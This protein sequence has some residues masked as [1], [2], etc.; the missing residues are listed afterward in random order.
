[1]SQSSDQAREHR[2]ELEE[3]K[4][5]M[6]SHL[7]KYLGRYQV[8][9]ADP[10]WKYANANV[11]GAASHH[12]KTMS[13][14]E[15]CAL[16]VSEIA[17]KDAMLLLWATSPL[18]PEALEVMEAWGFKFKTVFFAWVKVKKDSTTPIKANGYWTR[19]CLEVCLLGV[20]G[21]VSNLQK[22]KQSNSVA[23]CI[24]EPRTVHSKKP[25]ETVMERLREFFGSNYKRLNKVELFCRESVDPAH[26]EVWGNEAH[27]K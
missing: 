24:M 5:K 14:D 27:A 6:P 26:W 4:R 19:G 8:I 20:R 7:K 25:N 15:L 22:W 21:K 13:Q 10:A 23:Q 18:L 11:E 12:Y 3:R 9:Y 2:R 17:A 16:P 1:M